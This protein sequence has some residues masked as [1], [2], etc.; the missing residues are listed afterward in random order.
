MEVGVASGPDFPPVAEFEHSNTNHELLQL[1]AQ[2]AGH[3][4]LA[5]RMSSHIF[6]PPGL[7]QTAY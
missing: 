7:C 1:I 5:Q 4:S 2:E 6:E 3:R